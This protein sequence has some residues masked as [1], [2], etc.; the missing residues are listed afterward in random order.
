MEQL[1]QHYGTLH[2]DIHIFGVTELLE[3]RKETPGSIKD[4]GYPDRQRS[5][6]P[7]YPTERLH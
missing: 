6:H 7:L 1:F 2:D 4:S 5:E 3:H